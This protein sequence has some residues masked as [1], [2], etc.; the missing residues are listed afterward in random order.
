MSRYRHP[1]E[2]SADAL[3][4]AVRSGT[5]EQKRQRLRR[6]GI[7]TADGSIAPKY[8]NRGSKPSRTP[9]TGGE[10]ELDAE[11]AR[12][13]SRALSDP[14]STEPVEDVIQRMRARW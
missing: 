8:K 4:Q 10:D 12:R 6:V 14:G 5:Q 7:V 3:I 11:L 13:A 2:W 1:A 9:E